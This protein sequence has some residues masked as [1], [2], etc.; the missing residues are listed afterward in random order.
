MCENPFLKQSGSSDSD[1][2]LYAIQFLKGLKY[3]D[4]KLVTADD[5]NEAKQKFNDK[6]NDKEQNNNHPGEEN[7]K[8]ID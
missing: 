8:N 2:K 3:F 5:R 4:Y 7:D 1:Y 6:V